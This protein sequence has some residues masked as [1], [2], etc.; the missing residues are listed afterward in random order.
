MVLS[1]SPD[2]LWKAME[3]IWDFTTAQEVQEAWQREGLK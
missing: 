1:I 2:P 3:S